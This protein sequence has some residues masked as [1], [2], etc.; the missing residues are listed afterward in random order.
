MINLIQIAFMN[1]L[2]L[3]EIKNCYTDETHIIIDKNTGQITINLVPSN[4]KEC[5][6]FP[7]DVYLN[8]TFP[9][10]FISSVYM[11][12][13]N[14]EYNSIPLL[15]ID[16]DSSLLEPGTTIDHYSQ[17]TFAQLSISSLSEITLIELKSSYVKKSNLQQ[18]FSWLVLQIYS[19]SINLMAFPS[20]ECQL[21]ISNNNSESK[22]IGMSLVINDIEYIFDDY[23]V[24]NFIDSY[25]QSSMIFSSLYQDFVELNSQPFHIAKL[26]IISHQGTIDVAIEYP[27]TDIQVSSTNSFFQYSYPTISLINNSFILSVEIDVSITIQSI[28]DQID[29]LNYTKVVQRLSCKLNKKQF[30][31]Q[32]V[33]HDYF[34]ISNQSMII[35]CKQGSKNQQQYC[36]DFYDYAYDNNKTQCYLDILIY[37]GIQCISIEKIQFFTITTCIQRFSV[38]ISN[39]DVCV[40]IQ[41]KIN[42]SYCQTLF[43][44]VTENDK[45]FLSQNSNKLFHNGG[46]QNQYGMITSIQKFTNESTQFCFDCKN[47]FDDNNKLKCNSTKQFIVQPNLW[48][49]S[50]L[51]LYKDV[52]FSQKYIQNDYSIV[53]DV[54]VVIGC[55]LVLFALTICIY[56]IKATQSMITEAK[57]RKKILR[58]Q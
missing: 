53:Q 52:S 56:S 18:C 15:I 37:N 47:N 3:K 40:V 46:Y 41:Q 43:D 32:M 35:S 49:L 36:Q 9:S 23:Q 50:F 11:I 34:N 7:S 48:K 8:L 45:L 21:Q 12:Y 10:P 42:N 31:F 26:K 38:Q 44:F 1:K 14:F 5:E 16:V 19:S 22:M 58:S 24:Q 27:F 51:F 28:Q 6:V 2:K 30:T 57:H 20:N 17:I 29:Q 55:V 13:R 25:Q 4:N 54:V 39:N 33:V